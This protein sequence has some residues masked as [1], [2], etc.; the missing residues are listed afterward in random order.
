MAVL[1]V[2]IIR[3]ANDFKN[4]ARVGNSITV[5]TKGDF[6]PVDLLSLMENSSLLGNSKTRLSAGVR[7]L[8]AR[9]L[10]FA[11]ICWFV[12]R[13]RI[14]KILTSLNYSIRVSVV[15]KLFI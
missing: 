3:L 9:S 4:A 12:S 2:Y 11:Y 15:K 5:R 1:A 10:L 8:P 6:Q 14:C 7:G 13:K